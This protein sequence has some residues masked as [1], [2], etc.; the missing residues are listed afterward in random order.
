[1]TLLQRFWRRCHELLSRWHGAQVDATVEQRPARN[2]TRYGAGSAVTYSSLD[3]FLES[4]ENNGISTI[5]YGGRHIDLLVED[6]GFTTTV[7]IFHTALDPKDITTPVFVGHGLMEGVK[8][9]LVCC[10]DP[11][12]EL[13]VGLG[14]F[15]GHDG[16]LFQNDFVQILEHV[17]SN[18]ESHKEL[19]FYG[20]SGGGFAS[21]YFSAQFPNSLAMPLN[22]QTDIDAYSERAVEEY[23]LPAWGVRRGLEAPVTTNL[24]PLYSGNFQNY[25][26][27]L[28]NLGD[29]THI[30]KQLIPMLRNVTNS[31][32]ILLY[33]GEWGLGHRAPKTDI[34]RPLLQAVVAVDG[35]WEKLRE[36]FPLHEATAPE[37]LKALGTDYTLRVKRRAH[38]EGDQ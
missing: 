1:M 38:T 27:Y 6:R 26:F 16:V 8:A 5:E 7:V 4:N 21:L 23:C 12:L 22:P 14:W 18:M 9:N 2:L 35:D 31:N 29:R 37:Y 20:A 24:I 13:G 17:L 34:Q 25:V 11:V 30:N 3:D 32:R 36:I 15:A 19:V 33:L 10:S 28:Q